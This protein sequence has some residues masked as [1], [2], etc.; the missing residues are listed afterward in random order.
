[1]S[2]AELDLVSSRDRLELVISDRG[3]GFAMDKEP[4]PDGIGLISIQE[5]AFLAEGGVEIVSRPG[6]GTTIRA[7]FPTG[8]NGST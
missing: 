5:R 4:Q 7:R 6:A 1:V 3:Q 2:E 8:E